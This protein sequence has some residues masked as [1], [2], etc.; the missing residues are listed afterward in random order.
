MVRGQ[1]V[2]WSCFFAL[3]SYVHGRLSPHL[4]SP[5]LL[6]AEPCWTVK[7]H[8]KITQFVFEKFKPP[9]FVIV[10]SALVSL[11]AYSVVN[12]CVVDVGYDKVDVTAIADFSIS[13]AGRGVA[14]RN[15]GGDAMTRQLLKMLA[16][17]GFTKDMCE[18]LKRSSICEIPPP[19]AKLPG[20]S[21]APDEVINPADA[22]STGALGS[23]PGQR[24]SAGAL[25]ESPLVP[26][27]GTQVGDGAKDDIESDGVLD[28][29][30]IVAAGNKKMEEFLARK[31]KEKQRR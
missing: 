5:I 22:T 4:H 28:V 17:K 26:G 30:G 16:G 15:C 19:D 9:G 7:D 14:I 12:A 3:L 6:V 2:N 18:Q 20:L 24:V 25:G 27:P 21:E 1:I 8:E 11:W 10:D 31:E 13:L 29:A 23:G